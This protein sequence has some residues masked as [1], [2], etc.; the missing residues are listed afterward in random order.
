MT[1]HYYVM[2][3]RQ[4]S[5]YP[6]VFAFFSDWVLKEFS[7]GILAVEKITFKLKET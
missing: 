1:N 7:Q 2:F 3:T 4:L 5:E 6:P